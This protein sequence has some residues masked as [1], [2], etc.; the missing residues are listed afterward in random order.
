[1]SDAPG[2]VFG[3]DG[4]RAGWFFVAMKPTGKTE[5]GIVERLEKIVVRTGL[6]DRIFVDMPI[7]LPEP[8][9]SR[10]CDVEARKSLG[11]PRSSSVFPPPPRAVLRAGSYDEARGISLS[12]TGK[13]L[14]KQ[15][16]ALLPRIREVDSLM[17]GCEKARLIVREVHPEVC[18]WALN[19]KTSMQHNKRREDGRTER[20]DVLERH[21]ASARRIFDEAKRAF[22]RKVLQPDDILDALAIAVTGTAERDT[23]RTLPANPTRDSEGLPMEMVYSLSDLSSHPG[24]RSL[25][26]PAEEPFRRHDPANH[27]QLT[28]TIEA[29]REHDGRW[30]AEVI[31]LAGTMAYGES[32]EDATRR[33]KALALRVVAERLEEGEPSTRP[34]TIRFATA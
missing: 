14:S 3:V 24:S 10:P 26:P 9:D 12:T 23:L 5:W 15:T 13:S 1:M 2:T 8:G 19:G 32:R 28:L 17:R 30:I 29:E 22:P 34:S 25:F 7:G 33:A 11:A 27:M 18:F 6:E 16:Y 20:C 4:C 21:H 31:E